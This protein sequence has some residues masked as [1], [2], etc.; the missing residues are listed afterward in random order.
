[1]HLYLLPIHQI[2]TIPTTSP[3]S[4]AKKARLLPFPARM[5]GLNH[6]PIMKSLLL[7]LPSLFIAS[8]LVSAEDATLEPKA[9]RERAGAIFQ[10][11]PDKMPGADA[12]TPAMVKLGKDL[13]FEKR[14]SKNSTQS[15]NSCHRVDENR[16][17]VDNEPT[18]PGAFGERGGRNSP[19]TLNAGFHIAQFWDGRAATLEDQAKGPI[20]NPGEMAMPDEAT[21]VARI[22]EVEAY[23]KA[24]AEAFPDAKDPVTYNNI[25]EAIA[26]FERTLKTN[27]RFDDFLKGD[28]KAL[29]E[30]ERRG[31]LT[32]LNTGCIAC[33]LGPTMGGNLY[34]KMGLIEPYANTT[35]LGRAALTKNDA[36]KFFFK[37]PSL[38]NVGITGP[39]FHDGGAKTLEEAVSTMARIQLGKKLTETET[40]DIAAFLRSLSDKERSKATPAPEKKTAAR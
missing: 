35:D 18:S 37:V 31:L 17:G 40:A 33:H 12:D 10:P 24:F 14:L 25:A 16:G 38:R 32:F 30:P 7:A 26:A 39:Y 8:S 9:L 2:F 13:Y 5:N 36:E 29:S 23:T 15:C 20:L 28:D 27:D 19:T 11:L 3:Q 22:K 21:A 6:V 34:Q 1:M 4:P